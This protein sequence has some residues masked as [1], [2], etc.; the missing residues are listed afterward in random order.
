MVKSLHFHD[1]LLYVNQGITDAEIPHHTEVQT[2]II[3]TWKVWFAGL[4]V[5]LQ[6]IFVHH[7]LNSHAYC[8]S[9]YRILL[10][11]LPSP[12]ISGWHETIHLISV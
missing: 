5:E 1:L 7:F 11:L 4:K 10:A 9:Y 6:V 3:D 12:L 8:L 2:A